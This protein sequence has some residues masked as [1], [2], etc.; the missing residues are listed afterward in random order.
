MASRASA[1]R[2]RTGPANLPGEP[3]LLKAHSFGVSFVKGLQPK[4]MIRIA[5]TPEAFAAIAATFRSALSALSRTSAPRVTQ[6]LRSS[7]SAE[8]AP[9]ILI[10]LYTEL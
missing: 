6:S 9:N 4:L 10:F 1:R 8:A 7:P 2:F 3:N 5:I